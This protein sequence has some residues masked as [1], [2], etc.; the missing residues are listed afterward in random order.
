MSRSISRATIIWAIIKK[1]LKEFS[2]DKLLGIISVLALVFYVVIFWLLPGTVKETITL[3]IHQAGLERLMETLA[4][5]HNEGLEI[6]EF[7][8]SED[9]IKAVA[10]ELKL[11]KEV[12]IGIDFPEDFLKKVLS[13]EET[14]VQIYVDAVVPKEI[15]RAITS[16]IREISH[17][18]AGNEIPITEPDERTIVL[19]EDRAGNQ[20][21]FRARLLPML[22][23]MVLVMES[24]ALAVL[25]ANEV[26]SR[27]ITAVLVSPA[28]TGDVLAAKVLFGTFL[29]FSQTLLLLIAV[30]ALRQN[31]FLLI[32][33]IV[34]GT[35]MVS[36]LGMLT[37]AAGKD[38]M[39]TILIGML[40]LIP[41]AIPAISTI[42]PGTA[43]AW[44]KVLPSYGLVQGIV[45]VTTYHKGWTEL[46]PHLGF[47]I[48]WVV[49][50]LGVGFHTLKRKVETL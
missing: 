18:L 9:L 5:E 27:T 12:P 22:A 42:F 37:G 25:I 4:E 16:L 8:S 39:G 49:I 11:E 48:A 23:F 26:Q 17:Q 2:R 19:G 7:K 38:F 32:I 35:L 24:L 6:K 14:T 20:I 36:G 40:F 10:G 31:I 15:S 13:N 44:I 43:S 41:M 28:K 29:A 46:A 50:I 34:L 3:G 30:G 47:I 21:P 1:D 33:I 45:G